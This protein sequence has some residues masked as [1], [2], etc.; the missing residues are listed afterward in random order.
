M[1]SGLKIN[2]KKNYHFKNY[3]LLLTILACLGLS[4]WFIYRWY[5]AGDQPPIISL[6]AQL[7][8]D[9]EVIESPI[10]N[11]SMNGHRV[12]ATQPRYITVQ[13]INLEKA[14]VLPIGQTEYKTLELTKNIHDIGWYRES[15]FP[16]QGF[17]SV[18]LNGHG[19]GASTNG[20]FLNLKNLEIGNL[21]IIE[22]GDTKKIIYKVVEVRTEY[23]KEANESGMKR[24]LTPYDLNKEGLGIIGLSGKWIPRD[25][26]FDQRVLVR[27]VRT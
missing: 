12:L 3:I 6:P 10:S 11:N 7:V 14:R 15:A 4:F 22:R 21:I 8:S 26:I 25:K 23:I 19:K 27:A 20:P 16:G 24:L 1:S 9:P 5:T 17:G 2:T 13:S 18:L